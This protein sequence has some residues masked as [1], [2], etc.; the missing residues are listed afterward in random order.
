MPDSTRVS[1]EYVWD[2]LH[3][4]DEPLFVCAYDDPQKCRDIK[5]QGSIDMAELNAMLG[6]VPKDREIVLY[7]A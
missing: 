1:P 3:S 2:K 6:G 5:L 7:C 4:A